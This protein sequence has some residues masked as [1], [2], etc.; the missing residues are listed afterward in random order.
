MGLTSFVGLV[1]PVV[2][3]LKYAFSLAVP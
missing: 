1:E 2:F 3:E